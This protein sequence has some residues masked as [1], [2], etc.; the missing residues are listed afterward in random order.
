M[1]ASSSPRKSS[2][3]KGSVDDE[4]HVRGQLLGAKA[5]RG[6][7]DR[8]G[9]WPAGVPYRLRCSTAEISFLT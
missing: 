2:W 1:A 5:R 7:C 3:L 4:A 9:R 8:S 6:P